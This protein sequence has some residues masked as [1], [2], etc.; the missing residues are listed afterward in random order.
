[1]SVLDPRFQKLFLVRYIGEELSGLYCTFEL[2][3]G[4]ICGPRCSGQG[5]GAERRVQ[6]GWKGANRDKGEMGSI[7]GKAEP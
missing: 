3:S 1:M 2:F 4:I 7:L 5:I 6:F